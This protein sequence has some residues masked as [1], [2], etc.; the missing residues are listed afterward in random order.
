MVKQKST[1]TMQLHKLTA[2]GL[3]FLDSYIPADE[4]LLTRCRVVGG[5]CLEGACATKVPVIP[6]HCPAAPIY[7]APVV[8]HIIP[9]HNHMSNTRNQKL[10]PIS[11]MTVTRGIV[12]ITV[13]AVLTAMMMMIITKM[14]LYLTS[15]AFG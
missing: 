1:G 3:A 10:V 6:A 7:P 2:H 4:V 14:W 9:A 15:L 12:V 8:V 13:I 5:S 11:I